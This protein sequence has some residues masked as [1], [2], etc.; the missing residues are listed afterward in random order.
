MQGIGG[1]WATHRDMTARFWVGMIWAAL[2]V[3]VTRAESPAVGAMA[4][5]FSLKTL[6]GDVVE[7]DGL[8]AKG[9]VVLVMLRGYP[10]YQCPL[11]TRQVGEFVGRAKDFAAKGARVV[12]VYPGA[13]KDVAA[14]AREF[15]AGKDWP[16]EFVFLVDP[17]FA[18]TNAYGLRWE[19]KNETAYPATL[20]IGQ[21]GKV[22][23]SKVSRTH[24]GRASATEVLAALETR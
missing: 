9:P 5:E 22:K 13:A 4:P 18:F 6:A 2:M 14:R 11:C 24:G 10:E 7:L 16:A 3:T 20:V 17:D 12:M 1:A 23:W 21:E 8:R 19:A 15:M